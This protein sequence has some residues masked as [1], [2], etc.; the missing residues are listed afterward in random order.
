MASIKRIL[1]VGASG[2]G[3]VGDDGYKVVF[4]Q[5]LPEFELC[6]DSP[7]PDLDA[8]EWADAVVVG[9]GGLVYCNETAHF[10]YMAKYLD[11]ALHQGKPIGFLSAGVQI[12]PSLVKDSFLA[13]GPGF[14]APWE[15]YLAKAAFICVRSQTC[16]DIIKQLTPSQ[17]NLH[18]FP[19]ACYL[20]RPPAYKLTLPDAHVIIPTPSSAKSRDFKLAV[21]AI[22]KQDKVYV[23]SFSMD[24]LECVRTLEKT[25]SCYQNLVSR[26]HLSP[27]DAIAILSQAKN[28]ITSRYHGAVLARAAGIAEDCITLIDR[29]YKSQ[30]E[31]VPTDLQEASRQFDIVRQHWAI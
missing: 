2:Y 3:N 20:L 18:Y 9:G 22:P 1:C 28:V 26:T 23:A 13:D 7:Y 12:R 29:R 6:F 31:K 15:K 21:K 19:D 14:I 10:D 27:V 11:H 24:D 30:V 8:V 16:R 17:E 25:M 4:S 5:N